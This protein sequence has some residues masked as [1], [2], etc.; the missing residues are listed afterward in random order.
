MRS[1]MVEELVSLVP[2]LLLAPK[3]GDVAWQSRYRSLSFANVINAALS[4]TPARFAWICVQRQGWHLR[5][6]KEQ[7]NLIA[8]PLLLVA[9]CS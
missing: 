4:P 7:S 3:S 2:A 6:Q 9:T 8:M 1:A 5:P